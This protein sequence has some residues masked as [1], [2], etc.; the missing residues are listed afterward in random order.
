MRRF[1]RSLD[2]SCFVRYNSNTIPRQHWAPAP[3]QNT[4]ITLADEDFA[5]PEGSVSNPDPLF[6]LTVR[7]EPKVIPGT[8]FTPGLGTAVKVPRK[9]LP[10]KRENSREL[11]TTTDGIP[12]EELSPPPSL[13]GLGTMGELPFDAARMADA[14]LEMEVEG[15]IDYNWQECG[16]AYQE[17]VEALM[18]VIVENE[19]KNIVVICTK[20]K[21]FAFDYVIFV[22]CNGSR[23]INVVSWALDEAN[24]YLATRKTSKRL[25][26]TE[27]EPIP[28]GR[29]V[30]NLMTEEFRKRANFERKWAL[31]VS[32]DPLNFCN[33]AVSEG[34]GIGTHGLWTLTLNLQDLED[35]ETDYCRDA[36]LRQ[37]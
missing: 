17:D 2:L 11:E 37:Y 20:D 21:T 1:I 6:D 30:V 31:A 28:V 23:H 8:E 29:I 32:M 7:R 12:K 14:V 34:R 5:F 36:L 22:T 9:G 13:E 24:K 15:Q 33:N 19:G 10:L 27:W 35:F 16:T 25:M 26:D 4:K 3:I 18:K